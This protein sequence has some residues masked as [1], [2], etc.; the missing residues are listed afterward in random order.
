VPP[1]RAVWILSGLEHNVTS[2]KV[3][4]LRTLYEEPEAMQAP[5]PCCVVTID[6]L[7]RLATMPSFLPRPLDPRLLRL[8]QRLEQDPAE[9][10]SLEQLALKVG[11]SGRTAARLFV[12]ETGMTFGQWRQQLGLL[13]AMQYLGTGEGVASPWRSVTGMSPPLLRPS[14]RLLAAPQQN[15]LPVLL[16]GAP[17]IDYISTL[18]DL[19]IQHQQV[20]SLELSLV[21]VQYFILRRG[22]GFLVHRRQSVALRR[23][24]FA[25]AGGMINYSWEGK[26]KA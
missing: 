22:G 26:W 16:V 10:T 18:T 1:H 24:W 19:F 4:C 17:C 20:I 11:L 9:N 8:A 5:H 14:K 15:I 12:R 21:V 7:S 13:I 6:R 3:F 2:R 23:E 25:G